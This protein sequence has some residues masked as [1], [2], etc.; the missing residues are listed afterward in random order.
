MWSSIAGDKRNVIRRWPSRQQGRA[1]EVIGH[2]IEYLEDM[3]VMPKSPA[4]DIGD[5]EAVHLLQRHSMGI[6]NE[7]AEIVPSRIVRILGGWRTAVL[8]K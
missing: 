4:S 7:C 6:F 5:L 3:Y 2:A 1:L 8:S